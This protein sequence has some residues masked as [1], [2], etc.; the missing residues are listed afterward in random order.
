MGSDTDRSSQDN[1]TLPLNNFR[2]RPCDPAVSTR[3]G[4]G[5]GVGQGTRRAMISDVNEAY[6]DHH[7]ITNGWSGEDHI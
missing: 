3:V 5:I 1:V 2:R 6:C 7:I 4:I